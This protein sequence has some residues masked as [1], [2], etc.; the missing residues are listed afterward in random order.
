MT[1]GPKYF[2][3]YRATVLS[4]T[5][6]LVQGR[7]QVQ[8]SD[9]Y[10]LFPSTWALPAVPFAAKGAAGVIA[11][12]QTGS[13]VWVEFEAGDPDCPIWTGAFWPDPAGVPALAMAGTP[14]TPNIHLQTTTG[15]SVTLSDLPAAQVQVL[16]PTGASVVIGSAGI[17]ISNGQASIVLSGPS[18]IINGGALVVT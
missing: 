8:L 5:D 17:S 11:L 12:P 3:K 10:G 15:V 14:A 4:T 9:R 1:A 18:V 7:I 13:A 16:T 6:P 2:G